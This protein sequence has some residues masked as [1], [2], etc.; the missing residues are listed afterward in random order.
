[1]EGSNTPET[2]S[3]LV[4]LR[5]LQQPPAKTRQRGPEHT[6]LNPSFVAAFLASCLL[7][8]RCSINCH[9]RGDWTDG[10]FNKAHEPRREGCLAPSTPWESD[11]SPPHFCS[12]LHSLRYRWVTSYRQCLPLSMP[13]SLEL[14]EGHRLLLR[15]SP[16][17]GFSGPWASRK[18]SV[19]GDTPVPARTRIALLLQKGDELKF[20]EWQRKRSSDV[21]PKGIVLERT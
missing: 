2:L 19:E 1:M 11:A 10:R 20:I 8:S 21:S 15:F 18:D 12:V 17:L 16:L 4:C 14:L 7:S 3:V 9:C 13:P 6:G 5:G